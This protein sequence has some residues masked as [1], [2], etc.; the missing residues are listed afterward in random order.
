[1]SW[2]MA[3]LL[4]TSAIDLA[5]SKMQPAIMKAVETTLAFSP[6]KFGVLGIVQ[7]TS[8]ALACMVWARLAETRDRGP[9]LGISCYIWGTA[10]V[11]SACAFSAQAFIT[12]SLINGVALASLGPISQSV[13]P[14]LYEDEQRGRAFALL[15]AVGE[16]GSMCCLMLV[17]AISQLKLWGWEG[18]R[19]CYL[20]VGLVSY[21][22]AHFTFARFQDPVMRNSTSARPVTS[23]LRTILSCKTWS[24]ICLQGIFGSIPYAALNFTLM[25]LQYLGFSSLLAGVI[26]ACSTIGACAGSLVAGWVGDW[27]AIQ[28]PNHGRIWVAVL[29]DALRPPLLLLLYGVCPAYD[30]PAATYA[31]IIVCIGFL[32]PWPSIASNK[33]IFAEVV[34]PDMRA[35]TV[36]AQTV[37]ERSFGSLGGF[38]VGYVSE[39]KFGYDTYLGQKNLSELSV[40]QMQ[41]N[42]SALGNAMLITTCL[43]WVICTFLY[44]LLH[45]TYKHDRE[46]AR[47]SISY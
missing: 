41:Q 11:M 19:F 14:D 20:F 21:L 5:D 2:L 12:A 44:S 32:M 9:I 24:I 37:L 40:E 3:I 10:A 30:L 15:N 17:P 35:S 28:S 34:P 38:V 46:R 29:A 23:V 43:P 13:V 45:F 33:P 36:A 39:V 18:W 4:G 27:A 1:M 31:T 42:A 7:A 6:Q 22:W 16:I 26:T 25:W 8:S 47:M